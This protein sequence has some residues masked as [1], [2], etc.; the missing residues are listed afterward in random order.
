MNVQKLL[1]Y[2]LGGVGVLSAIFLFMII[3]AG[4]DAIKAGEAG[5][6]VNTFMYIAYVVLFLIVAIVLLFVLKGLFSG[7]IKKTL[8]SVGAFLAIVFI[9]YAM[10]SGTDL[11]LQ[12]F[13]DKGADVTEATSKKVGA[14]LYTFYVLGFLAIASMAFSGVKKIFNK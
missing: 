10:S 4:D 13:I 6:S 8:I 3:S 1:T 5:G 7:D 12:P 11:N 9:S 14:G 2:I